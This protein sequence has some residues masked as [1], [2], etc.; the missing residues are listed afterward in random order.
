MKIDYKAYITSPQWKVRSRLY[1]NSHPKCELCGC[2]DKFKLQTHHISYANIGNEQDDDLMTLCEDC[3]EIVEIIKS[4]DQTKPVLPIYTKRCEAAFPD[5]ALGE[6]K[7]I[8]DLIDTA[9]MNLYRYNAPNI[10]FTIEKEIESFTAEF[11]VN[12]VLD[13]EGK[14]RPTEIELPFVEFNLWQGCDEVKAAAKRVQLG[15]NGVDE[16]VTYLKE[17]SDDLFDAATWIMLENSKPMTNYILHTFRAYCVEVNQCYKDRYPNL[18]RNA[19]IVALVLH[20]QH[21]IEPF[22]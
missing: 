13:I 8:L 14:L 17:S 12:G 7:P 22:E 18:A 11:S 20:N 19:R 6:Y 5:D 1:R 10:Y 4:Y 15:I 21:Y 9:Y 16:R 2:A 3:H